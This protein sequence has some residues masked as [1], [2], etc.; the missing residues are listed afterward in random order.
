VTLARKA[1]TREEAIA[2][3]RDRKDAGG[4]APDE[5]AIVTYVRQ[6]LRTNRVEQAVFDAL[7]DRYGVPWI[8]ELTGIIGHYGMITGLLNAF[9]MLPAPDAEQLPV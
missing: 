5:R 2:V 1:G 4:L 6:L 9:E 7:K 3:V 8:V